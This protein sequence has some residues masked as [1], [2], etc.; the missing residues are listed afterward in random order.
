M[1][2]PEKRTNNTSA[3]CLGVCF[4]VHLA[5][6]TSSKAPKKRW[7]TQGIKGKQQIGNPMCGQPIE[8]VGRNG[9][10]SGNV[11][12]TDNHSNG[13][14]IKQYDKRT[15]QR[16][17]QTVFRLLSLLLRKKDTVMGTMGKTHGVTKATNPKAMACK[18]ILHKPPE[19]PF[20]TVVISSAGVLM[21]ASAE[22]ASATDF[23]STMCTANVSS[24]GG[25]QDVPSHTC[26]STVAC[27]VAPD[28][29][30]R[31]FCLN[32]PVPPKRSYEHIKQRI[33]DF[34]R[35]R[36]HGQRSFQ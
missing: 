35:Y 32:T 4:V 29:S 23:L 5:G 36:V 6:N 18:T 13:N 21:T 28:T 33:V 24:A 31:T 3:V 19:V 11:R 10:S 26:H 22:T 30:R 2:G 16:G 15:V 27:T 1:S 12:N 34:V 9:S 8:N 20:D 25:K 7:Q 14:C 17:L